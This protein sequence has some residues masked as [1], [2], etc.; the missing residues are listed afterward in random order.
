[1]M[2]VRLH[3]LAARQP[4]VS[5]LRM[6]AELMVACNVAD[7]GILEPVEHELRVAWQAANF[8]V[9]CDA[10]VIVN[11]TQQIVGY[12]EVRHSEQAKLGQLVAA[13][14]VHPDYR[15]RGIGTLLTWLLENRARQIAATL[16]E[17][18]RVTLSN[19]V[20][21]LDHGAQALLERE[22]Y[23]L[24]RH[25]WRF[26]IPMEEAHSEPHNKLKVDLVVAAHDLMSLTPAR[27][28]MYH[29]RQYAVYEKVIQAE[30]NLQEANL[31]ELE[32]CTA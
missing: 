32:Y 2:I 21:S 28:G 1:M 6:I 22:G 18:V 24:L 29:A 31:L 30:K 20:C 27:T 13:V 10:W 3:K 19:T 15:G 8:N 17:Y 14:Y 4:A 23:T 5:D 11:N 25:F 26:T 16:P 9:K 12:A 7:T